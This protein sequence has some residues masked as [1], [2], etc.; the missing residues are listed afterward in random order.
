MNRPPK[1]VGEGTTVTDLVPRRGD[2]LAAR[3][4]HQ[5]GVL[6]LRGAIAALGHR[7]PPVGPDV[8]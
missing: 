1:R 7:R 8:V 2:D 3:L 5:D 4:C 6:E